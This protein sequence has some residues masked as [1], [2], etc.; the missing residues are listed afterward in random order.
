[1][2]PSALVTGGRGIGRAIAETLADLHFDVAIVYRSAHLAAEETASACRRSGARAL[3]IKADISKPEERARILQTLSEAFER[4]DVLVNNAGAAPTKRL[5]ILEADE[6]SYDQ[7]M[8]TN[9][10]APYF[11]TQ[12]IAK[13]M[14]AEKKKDDRYQPQIINIS[15]ISAYT[16]S[17]SRGEYCLS[18]AAVA[19]M[20]Q[21]YADRL[22][23]FGIPVFEIR[24]G[25][26]RTDMTAGV[27]E[28]YNK[29]IFEQNLTPIHRWGEPQDVARAVSAIVQGYFSFSTGE[30]LNVDGGFHLR[31]L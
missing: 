30:I 1:M 11:L 9:I 3:V 13:W 10:K 31:R 28:K 8:N 14:I 20:T 23:D 22:A 21:L 5:D 27:A 15:S 17:P 6:E 7:V 18:K 4:L 26:I 25:I 12:K 19:M 24:P 16:S 29:L 2:N